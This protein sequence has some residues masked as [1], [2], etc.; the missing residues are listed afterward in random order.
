VR[1]PGELRRAEPLSRHTTYGIGGPADAFYVPERVEGLI[2]AV[3]RAREVGLPFKVIGGGSNILFS[4]RGFRGL[5][6]ST[7]EVRRIELS[8]RTATVEAGVLLSR[9]IDALDRSGRPALN[10]FSGIPGS[11]GGAIAM[12]TGAYGRSIGDIVVDLAVLDASGSLVTWP[13]NRCGFAYRDSAV[14]REKV[15]ILSARLSTEGEAVDRSAVLDRRRAAQPWCEKSAGC[16]FRN[17]PGRSAGRLIE[18]AGLKGLTV[19]KVKVSERHANFLVNLG[20][21]SSAEICKIID[22][23]RQR[24]YKSSHISLDLEIE[25][26]DG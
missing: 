8:D 26:I 17:P 3:V 1:L 14:R 21:G 23:V 22:I 6:I 24:V 9:L 11:I 20:G 19:G 12:N 25:V 18:E 13:A 7:A 2:D 15:V 16:V 5:V 4:D 10:G